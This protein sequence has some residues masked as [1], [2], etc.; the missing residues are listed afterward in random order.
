MSEKI[1]IGP[2]SDF[3]P[4]PVVLVGVEIDNRPNYLTVAW[5]NMLNMNPPVIGIS[6]SKTHLDNTYIKSAKSFSVNIPAVSQVAAVD[7]C[8]LK[9]VSDT[10]K[11]DVFTT[12]YGDLENA[13][14]IEE[15]PV[16]Y[17]CKLIKSIEIGT[18]ELFVGKIINMFS[19]NEY[20]SDGK[21]DTKKVNPLILSMHDRSYW[22][23]GELV[24][25]AWSAGEDFN[26]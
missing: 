26:N 17:E 3:F 25:K 15:C 13:P 1:K 7:Y 21:P 12:F 16:N 4:L 23:L 2:S 14:M 8:G 9:S 24:D 18:T 10:D 20:M 22:E 6:L 11:S 5:V 19:N